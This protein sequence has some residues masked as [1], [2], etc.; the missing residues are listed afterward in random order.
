MNLD[1][2]YALMYGELATRYIDR[3]EADNAALLATRAV[4]YAKRYALTHAAQCAL[5]RLLRA[6]RKGLNP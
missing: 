4:H 2:Q 1:Q 5:A 6:I 3:G